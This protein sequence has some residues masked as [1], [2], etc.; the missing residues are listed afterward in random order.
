M[1]TR[2]YSHLIWCREFGANVTEDTY[3]SDL[4]RIKVFQAWFH[5][6]VF[7]EENDTAVILPYGN[8]EPHY[9]QDGPE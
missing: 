9:R 5:E 1:N 7:P 2:I 6:N 3:T 8:V 4:N